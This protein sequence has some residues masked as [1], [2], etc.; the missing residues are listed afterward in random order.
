MRGGA[1]DGNPHPAGVRIDAGVREGDTISPYYD[2][3]IAKLIVWGRDRDEA[4]AR[5]RQ[6]LAAWVVGLSTNV[7]FLQRLVACEAFAQADLDTGLIERNRAVLFPPAAPVGM[8][9][10]AL[11]VAALQARGRPSAASTRPIPTRPGCV[12][13]PGASMAGPGANCAWPRPTGPSWRSRWSSRAA[14]PRCSSP[15]RPRR[16]RRPVLPRTSAWNGARAGCTVGCTPT[17]SASTSSM[18]AATT[19]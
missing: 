13:G 16:S 6:A 9:A 17:G 12:P 1:V 5:M 18:M 2:P 7:A 10:I 3:M 8:E 19:S 15:T 11:A 14:V 4:L